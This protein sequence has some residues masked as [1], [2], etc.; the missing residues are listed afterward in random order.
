MNFNVNDNPVLIAPRPVRVASTY[1]HFARSA[2]LRLIAAP[3]D[4]ERVKISEENENIDELKHPSRIHSS[5]SSDKESHSPRASPRSN[6]PSE[7]LEEF[8]SILRPAM[9]PPSSPILRPRRNGAV[10]LPTFGVSYKPRTKIDTTHSK[11]DQA[12]S[13][14]AEESDAEKFTPTCSPEPVAEHI[15]GNWDTYG[16]EIRWHAQILGFTDLVG[17]LHL[18]S[19]SPISRMHTRNPFPRH[20]SQDMTLTGILSTRSSPA[21]TSTPV[22]PAAVP[23]PVPS[24]DE[25]LE[26]F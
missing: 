21:V 5:A 3:I 10:S 23:L 11:G 12:I 25:M 19:A 7:A 6:L 8:L 2:H 15:T 1:P 26:V 14:L 18:W 24:P 13:N 4:S 22:S 20:G 16:S 9:F 17:Y